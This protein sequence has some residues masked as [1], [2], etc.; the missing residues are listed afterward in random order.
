[1]LSLSKMAK[2]AQAT[3]WSTWKNVVRHAIVQLGGK[4][5]LSDLYEVIA[6]MASD[7]IGQNKHWKE[8]VRQTLQRADCFEPVERGVWSLTA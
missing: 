3:L 8:K 7:R 4:A 6:G 5:S 1:M 2:K